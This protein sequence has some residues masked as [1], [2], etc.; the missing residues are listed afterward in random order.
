MG[1][2]CP[3]HS[4]L[5][6]LEVTSDASGSWGC[7]AWCRTSSLQIQWGSQSK[8]LTITE[9]ELVP[10]IMPCDTWGKTWQGRRVLCHCY[11]QIVVACMWS[12]TSKESGLMHLL[13]CLVFVEAQNQCYLHPVYIDTRSN[14]LADDLFRNNASSF[15]SNLLDASPHPSP[16]SQPLLNLLLDRQADWTSPSWHR[17]FSCISRQD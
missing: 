10:I 3:H 8:P 11:N 16:V 9:K 1:Y 13:R 4:H 12:R 17:Q 5:P 2:P 6:Q 15:L 14:H 7:G